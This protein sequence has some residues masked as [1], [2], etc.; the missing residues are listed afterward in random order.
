MRTLKFRSQTTNA[1]FATVNQML[2]GSS[3]LPTT[4][5]HAVIKSNSDNIV[6]S[7]EEPPNIWLTVAKNAFVGWTL[8]FIEKRSKIVVNLLPHLKN[9]YST[10]NI[11][12][13]LAI[14]FTNHLSALPISAHVFT[15]NHITHLPMA[16]L[17]IDQWNRSQGFL[18]FQLTNTTTWLSWKMASAQVVETSVTNNSP[19]QDSNHPDDL[20]QS[21][22]IIVKWYMKCFIYW[23]ADFEIK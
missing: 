14:H 11:N 12:T 22:Y 5:E 13:L 6:E 15:V 19:S 10:G 3:Q 23:T 18:N 1:F 9:V 4:A 20:F 16:T 2:G 7:W 17:S 21:K 8:N